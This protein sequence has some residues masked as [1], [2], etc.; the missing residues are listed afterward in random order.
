MDQGPSGAAASHITLVFL[1]ND[2]LNV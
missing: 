2:L 1:S